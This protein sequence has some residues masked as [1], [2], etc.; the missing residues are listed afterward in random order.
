M[1]NS[2]VGF[3]LLII[4]LGV[5]PGLF[6]QT[7]KSQVDSI[8]DWR[9]MSSLGN[10]ELLRQTESILNR[11]ASRFQADQSELTIRQFN[12]G[13]AQEQRADFERNKRV[14]VPVPEISTQETVKR[15]AEQG[16]IRLQEARQFLELVEAEKYSLERYIAQIDSV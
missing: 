2:L 7:H 5:S 13:Q 4:L 1:Q 12:F 8:G 11:G 3:G 6:S 9:G 15:A 10:D 14:F 16:K